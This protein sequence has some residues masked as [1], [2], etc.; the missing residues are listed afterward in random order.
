MTTKPT[1]NFNDWSKLDLR[2]GQ[3]TN[4]EDIEGA[5][6]LYKLTVDF[7]SEIGQ[8]TICAGIKKYISREDLKGRKSIFLVNLEPRKL[9]GV[10][11]QGM[12]IAA[13]SQAEDKFVLLQP[14]EDIEVGSKIS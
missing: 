13:G 8:R 4:V 1:I 9:K 7:G 5:D 2:V 3:I 14:S 12:I 6:K 10:E 11:S